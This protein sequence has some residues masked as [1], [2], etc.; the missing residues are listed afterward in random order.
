[1]SDEATDVFN[2]TGSNRKDVK[3]QISKHTRNGKKAEKNYATATGI[4]YNIGWGAGKI[5]K[6]SSQTIHK[7]KKLVF[8]L[9]K[10]LR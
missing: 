10:R 2:L 7:G 8:K 5:S 3:E 1:M 4:G 6:I 9:L